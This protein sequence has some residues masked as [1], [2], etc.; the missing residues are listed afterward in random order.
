M[1]LHNKTLIPNT[2]G[3]F[4]KNKRKCHYL[5][6][7][8]DVH[9]KQHKDK[10][11]NIINFGNFCKKIKKKTFNLNSHINWYRGNKRLGTMGNLKTHLI[12]VLRSRICCYRGNFRVSPGF[13]V[14]GRG[15]TYRKSL[16]ASRTLPFHGHEGSKEI[17][18]SWCEANL[19]LGFV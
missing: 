16:F 10:L 19:H 17:F 7:H 4:V 15:H 12:P 11:Y 1:G 13:S 14:L 2:L 5:L 9:W 18:P 3:H 8:F 6:I